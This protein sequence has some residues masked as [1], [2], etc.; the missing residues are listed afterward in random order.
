VSR[1]AVVGEFAFERLDFLAEY[2]RGVLA[3]AFERGKDLSAQLRVFR[4]QIENRNFHRATPF[5]AG[6]KLYCTQPLSARSDPSLRS[7]NQFRGTAKNPPEGTK[8]K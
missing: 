2:E 3:N 6:Q 1:L 7:I 4:L 5:W 8:W